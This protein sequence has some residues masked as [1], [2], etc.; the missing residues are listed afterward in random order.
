MSIEAVTR[1]L[2]KILK[3]SLDLDTLRAAS[4]AWELEVT[5]AVEKD[6]D[7][8]RTVRELEDAYDNELLKGVEEDT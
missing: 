4:T 7:L 5:S 6:E 3:L 8:T 2:A 1:R